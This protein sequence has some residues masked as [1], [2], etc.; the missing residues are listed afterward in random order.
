MNAP[1]V[2]LACGLTHNDPSHVTCEWCRAVQQ[3]YPMM[4]PGPARAA[5][6]TARRL[7]A[8][9]RDAERA[10]DSAPADWTPML[11]GGAA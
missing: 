9:R 3:Q 4:R 10:P 1:R 2:C 6:L 7:D 5:S 8:A 11:A